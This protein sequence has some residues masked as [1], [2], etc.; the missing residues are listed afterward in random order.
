MDERKRLAHSLDLVKSS[1]DG[2]I[3]LA[4][5][6]DGPARR[7]R[8]EFEDKVEAVI[9]SS[10]AKIAQARF[11]V[12]GA[13]E[14]PDATFTLRLTYGQVKGY[15]D[16]RGHAVPYATTLRGLVPARHR[17]RTFRTSAE[18]DQGEGVAQARYAL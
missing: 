1:N 14:Y 13:N 6:L 11:A 3:R 2:M 9:N 10:A 5:I 17:Q 4:L 18:L 16:A 12:Y 7:Y 15:E 8:R